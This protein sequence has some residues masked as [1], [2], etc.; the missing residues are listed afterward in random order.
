MKLSPWALIFDKLSDGTLYVAGA[1]R[2]RA[3]GNIENIS[4]RYAFIEKT[5]WVRI[6]SGTN[7]G[8][9][10]DFLN[11]AEGYKGRGPEDKESQKWC[12]DML[13]LLGYDLTWKEY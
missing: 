3:D 5:P 9:W 4:D 1:T 12:D 2:I 8:Q 6:R 10:E 11:W 13:V 7:N